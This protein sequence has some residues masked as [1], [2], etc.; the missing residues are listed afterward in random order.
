[1]RLPQL[2]DAVAIDLNTAIDLPSG[3]PTRENGVRMGVD[4]EAGDDSCRFGK[5]SPN[6]WPAV[7]DQGPWLGTWRRRIE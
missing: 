1:M 4:Q 6:D 3:V 7:W 2:G 5:F